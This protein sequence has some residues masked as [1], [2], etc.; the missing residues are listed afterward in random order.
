MIEAK[1]LVHRGTVAECIQNILLEKWIAIRKDHPLET[2]NI[3][4]QIHEN[5]FSNYLVSDQSVDQ[6]EILNN[7]KIDK[8]TVLK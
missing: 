7:F 5:D 3:H 4:S 6:K 2:I 8:R 1:I